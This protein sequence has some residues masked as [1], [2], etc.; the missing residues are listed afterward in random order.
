M[1]KAVFS[2][3]LILLV[4]GCNGQDAH[5][6]AKDELAQSQKY[7]DSLSPKPKVEWKVNK[8]Y[9]ENGNVIGYDSI[10][11]WSYSNHGN[12]P[13]EMNAD[14]IM[15]SFRSFSND[16]FPS[17][18]EDQD[19]DHIFPVDSIMKRNFSMD[20]FFNQGNIKG[21]PNMDEWMQKMDSLRNKMMENTYPEMMDP[22]KK[23]QHKSEKI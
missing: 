23:M 15:Q 22:H 8:K 1:R 10:Y 7:S 17:F 4:A 12:V 16:N 3:F 13:P 6:N 5:N 2:L 11:S 9:D 20:R 14:S 18:W 21:F 19:L